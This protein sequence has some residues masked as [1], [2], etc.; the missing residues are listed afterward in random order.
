MAS[1][2][3]GQ[4]L[5]WHTKVVDKGQCPLKTGSTMGWVCRHDVSS[6]KPDTLGRDEID[7]TQTNCKSML[8]GSKR[9]KTCDHLV[10]G[11]TF[12][13]TVTKRVYNVV[14]PSS[15]VNCSTTNVIYLISCRKC[16]I[17]YVGETG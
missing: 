1:F 15:I 3:R 6:S 11:S 5:A 4:L 14:S 17:Q 7:D 12:T 16:G 13:S 2:D 10:V 8:C 9:C